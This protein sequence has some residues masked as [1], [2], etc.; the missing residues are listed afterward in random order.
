MAIT[1]TPVASELVMIMDYGFSSSGRQQTKELVL[2][3]LIPGV[4]LD[5]VYAAAQ[6]VLALQE[7]SNLAIRRRDIV[8]LKN[9]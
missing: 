1:S 7:K 2:K 4:A 9:E 8:E 5:D 3:S 6:V